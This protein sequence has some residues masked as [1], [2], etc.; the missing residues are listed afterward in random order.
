[1]ESPPENVENVV[2]NIIHEYCQPVFNDI[3]NLPK[4]INEAKSKL[5]N[6]MKID[7]YGQLKEITNMI[8][9][10]LQSN[11]CI[12]S[13][14]EQIETL[15]NL[16]KEL[17][18]HYENNIKL[19]DQKYEKWAP[20]PIN[21]KQEFE[22]GIENLK[23]DLIKQC[24]DDINQQQQIELTNTT[25]THNSYDIQIKSEHLSD[26]NTED[27]NNIEEQ[28]I[29]QE[30]DTVIHGATIIEQ[31]LQSPQTKKVTDIIQCDTIHIDSQCA[32]D[33]I[34]TIIANHAHKIDDNA[35]NTQ[36]DIDI[37]EYTNTPPCLEPLTQQQNIE[38]VNDS[39]I[40]TNQE[41][42]ICM[43]INS[44]ENDSTDTIVP[45]L[46]PLNNYIEC[47]LCNKLVDTD[48]TV[49]FDH[50]AR[51]FCMI[52]NSNIEYGRDMLYRQQNDQCYDKHVFI[53]NKLKQFKTFMCNLCS[54]ITIIEDNFLRHTLWHQGTTI[55]SN[56]S[57]N[58]KSKPI[59]SNT[60]ISVNI[61]NNNKRVPVNPISSDNCLHCKICSSKYATEESALLDYDYHSREVCKVC[62][63]KFGIQITDSQKD[64][65]CFHFHQF[66]LNKLNSFPKLQCKKCAYITVIKNNFDHHIKSHKD[67]LIP[68]S[69]MASSR[70]NCL[71]TTTHYP[72]TFPC[73]YC[74]YVGKN[75][76]ALENHI[77]THTNQRPFVC[78][79]CNDRFTVKC[80]LTSHI[81]NKHENKRQYQCHHCS[82]SFNSKYRLKEHLNTHT[83]ETPH[84]CRHCHEMFGSTS[85][86]NKHEKNKHIGWKCRYC[87][88]T[89]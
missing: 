52:C 87:D 21:V 44:S 71:P 72:A 12:D 29:K 58:R 79:I 50:H 70:D 77:R 62:K 65:K 53:I 56:G 13:N 5:L 82:R 31:N 68:E 85:K 43:N 74:T 26:L 20:Y 41:Q 3:S 73:E 61:S 1:M 24:I 45:C 23:Q 18:I 51:E 30:P 8:L 34:E 2:N 7:Y 35:N 80:N 40:N 84:K 9:T 48:P 60:N 39:K 47:K 54:Y 75:N 88:D 25:V 69:L 63:I 11:D 15:E 76:S 6:E 10:L 64:M 32:G 78:D 17:D 89:F 57:T 46:E 83:G 27:N 38:C 66:I 49:H 86:R 67:N 42:K 37:N 28:V 36:I 55:Y 33:N 16:K 22:S 59:S 19:I 14:N 4:Q 81:H